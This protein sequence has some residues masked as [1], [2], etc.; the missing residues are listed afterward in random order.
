LEESAVSI[1]RLLTWS[2]RMQVSAKLWYLSK[3]IH[4][5]TSLIS[6]IRHGTI[7]SVWLMLVH[8]IGRSYP[9]RRRHNVATCQELIAAWRIILHICLSYLLPGTCAN[10]WHKVKCAIFKNSDVRMKHVLFQFWVAVVVQVVKQ[11]RLAVSKGQKNEY[12]DLKFF[13]VFNEF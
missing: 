11:A 3:N 2:W 1:Y 10:D 12:F 13:F 6:I 8:V 4:R 9:P 7:C 5:V